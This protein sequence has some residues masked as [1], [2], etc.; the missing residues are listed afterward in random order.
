MIRLLE[1]GPRSL[2]FTVTLFP[3]V[4]LSTRTY[5]PNLS[6]LWAQVKAVLSYTSPL[7]VFLPWRESA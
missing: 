1:K 3:L 6:V 5:V 7:A 4:R 2:T